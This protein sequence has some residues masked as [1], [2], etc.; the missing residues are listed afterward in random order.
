MNLESLLAD[1]PNL[2]A[3][4]LA[5][6]AGVSSQSINRLKRKMEVRSSWIHNGIGIPFISYDKSVT[7]HRL[8]KGTRT[9]Y[10]GTLEGSLVNLDR[11]IYCLENN[12]GKLPP[13]L[14]E[15]SLSDL[16][17]IK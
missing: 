11:L 16:E 1:N 10:F 6:L 15:W 13:T 3:S 9:L 14:S 17:F 5:K 8:R 2:K 4:S 12:N 7:A